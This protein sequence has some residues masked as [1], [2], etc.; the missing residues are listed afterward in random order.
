MRALLA[1]LLLTAVATAQPPPH[2]E[3][4]FPP[5]GE[6]GLPPPDHENAP[7]PIQRLMQ[8]W[9]ERNPEE[10]ERMKALREQDP[11][12][13]R[14]EL[15][16]KLQEAR[17]ARGQGRRFMEEMGGRGGPGG[18]REPM[19][20][21]MRAAENKIRQIAQAWRK[22]STEEE[23][24]RLAAELKGALNTMFDQREQMRATRLADME[25]K[26]NELRAAMEERKA[27]RD[28]IIEKRLHELTGDDTLAW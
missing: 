6:Q 27:R 13:F 25:K 21:E 2:E 26:L 17:E 3:G 22:A 14:R 10:F 8:H 19:S 12:A 5:P 11:E 7:P 18:E 23:K 9:K 28:D 24:A 4:D 15:E 1:L 16:V 20:P